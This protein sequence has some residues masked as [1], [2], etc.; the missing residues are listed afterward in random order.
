[1]LA[2]TAIGRAEGWARDLEAL[3][4]RIA[5]RFVR[6]EPRRRA[7]AYLRGLLA[8]VERKNGWQ[9]AEAAG[10]PTP[11]GVQDFLARMRWDADAVRDDLRAYVVEHLGDPDAVLALDETG[12]IKKGDKSAG[13]QRQYSGTAGRIENCQVGVFLGYAGRHGRALI[14]RALYLPERWTRDAARCAAAGIPN[15][16]TLTTKPKLGLAMLD[17]ALDAGV[18]FAW[19]AGDS[20]Y[21]S[22]HRIRRRLEARQRG[23]VLAV[24]SGQRLGFVPVEDWL[25]KVPP[26][27]WRRLS[28]GDGAKGPRLYDWAY[29]P[30]RGA[31]PGWRMGL[32]IRRGPAKPD[33]LAYY[34][35][36][37]PEGTTLARLARV[38]G[39]R[40]TI[41]SCFEAAK[42]E[43]G[44]DEYEVR[45]WTGWHR[46]ITLAMLAHAYLAVLRKAALGGSG[47]A[48][49]RRRSAAPHRAGSAAPALAPR[50]EP[51][52]GTCRRPAL[53]RLAQTPPATR[54]TMPLAQA[55]TPA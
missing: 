55:D 32:L 33:D 7:L 28:A 50:L 9:L 41:E 52:T 8:P 51:R 45:S 16:L 6:A 2:M 14:D 47:R 26:D 31:A 44:L 12:F 27:G 43:V 53:V 38:A 18:P 13:V 5:P 10:D 39:T 21:G 1:M 30:Y 19:V 20:V 46:H 15:G 29:L 54:T 11:D 3:A 23:Y 36:H 49:S 25:A 4:E 48:R 24:T 34:L 35:T 42:G 22:D 37:A 17:R 40:W